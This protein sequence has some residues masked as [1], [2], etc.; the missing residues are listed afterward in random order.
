MT[1]IEEDFRVSYNRGFTVLII[2]KDRILCDTIF[3]LQTFLQK[4]ISQHTKSLPLFVFELEGLLSSLLLNI[5]QS[6]LKIKL[7][8]I[9]T[10]QYLHHEVL[11]SCSPLLRTI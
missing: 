4:L 7:P 2:F 10:Y 9:L 8:D 3:L 5:L 1:Q 11:K 6:S